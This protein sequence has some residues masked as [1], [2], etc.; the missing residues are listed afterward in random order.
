MYSV[1]GII[2]PLNKEQHFGHCQGNI[3]EF[4]VDCNNVGLRNSLLFGIKKHL[5]TFIGLEKQE[6]LEGLCCAVHS[7]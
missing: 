6:V 3:S 4:R 2:Q 1:D 7:R 5:R